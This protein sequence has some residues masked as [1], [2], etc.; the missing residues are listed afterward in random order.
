MTSGSHPSTSPPTFC[1]VDTKDLPAGNTPT[2][3]RKQ[4]QLICKSERS[5]CSYSW[6][7]PGVQLIAVAVG[8]FMQYKH[9]CVYFVAAGRCAKEAHRDLVP[10]SAFPIPTLELPRDVYLPSNQVLELLDLFVGLGVLLQVPLGEESLVGTERV[11]EPTNMPRP[12]AVWHIWSSP[13]LGREPCGMQDHSPAVTRLT[14]PQ[15][16]PSPPKHSGRSIQPKDSVHS[17]WRP[18]T[19]SPA[20]LLLTAP[21]NPQLRSWAAAPSCSRAVIISW[22]C[23]APEDGWDAAPPPCPLTAHLRAAPFLPWFPLCLDQGG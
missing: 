21:R 12:Q 19:Q 2:E 17:L 3:G 23:S 8:G 20:R 7:R 11:A 5:R 22:A 15:V 1:S 16:G 13:G 14:S 4:T 9:G 18:C 6:Q 10:G